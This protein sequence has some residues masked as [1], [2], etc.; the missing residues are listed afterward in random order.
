MINK[1][2]IKTGFV[3]AVVLVLAL[4]LLGMANGGSTGLT[5]DFNRIR[6]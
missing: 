5:I 4:S 3:G 1:E 2:A 6:V